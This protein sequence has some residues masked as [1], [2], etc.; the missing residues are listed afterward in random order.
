M[1]PMKDLIQQLRRRAF[2]QWALA[3][4]GGAWLLLQIVDTIAEP[5]GLSHGIER[6]I[7]ISLALGFLLTVVL[8]W[9]HGERG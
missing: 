4:L 7:Q 9:Y 6:G 8:S 5:W 3:Y 2:F 1:E